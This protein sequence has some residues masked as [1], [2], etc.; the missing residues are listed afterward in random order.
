MP[1]LTQNRRL[2][3]SAFIG[4]AFPWIPFLG[5]PGVFAAAIWFPEGIHSTRGDLYLVL[6]MAINFILYAGLSYALLTGIVTKTPSS[7]AIRRTS[8]PVSDRPVKGIIY[9]ES[10]IEE[11]KRRGLM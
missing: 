11:F 5:A 4:I 2:G 10:E 3:I 8:E 1:A 7:N 6:A 9:T